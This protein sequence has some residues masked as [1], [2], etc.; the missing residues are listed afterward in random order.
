VRLYQRGGKG[1]YYAEFSIPGVGAPVRKSTHERDRRQA[2]AK[3]AAMLEAETRQWSRQ[4]LLFASR[5]NYRWERACADWHDARMREGWALATIE[6]DGQN[7]R[8]LAQATDGAGT[9]FFAGKL[10]R[11]IDGVTIGAYVTQALALGLTPETVAKR[12]HTLGQILTCARARNGTDGR[13]LLAEVPPFPALGR[14]R[15]PDGWGRALS[16][17]E[18]DALRLALP[19]T[20]ETAAATFTPGHRGGRAGKAVDQRGWAEICLWTAQ[21][22]DDVNHFVPELVNL[23]PVVGPAPRR[24]PPYSFV[25][26]NSKNRR[27]TA[28]KIREQVRRMTHPLRA[29]LER[30]QRVRGFADGVPIAGRWLRGNIWRDM[31]NAARRAGIA[32]VI[33]DRG[34][35]HLVSPNDLRRTAATWIAE[36]LAARGSG[37][38]KSAIEL[39][40]EFLGHRGIDVARAIYDRAAG[41]RLDQVTDVLDALAGPRVGPKSAPEL[42]ADIVPLRRQK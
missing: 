42:P 40:A 20:G 15:D 17:E 23:A 30:M 28:G 12:C 16:R 32:P 5:D 38:D 26:R 25:W 41:T 4:E 22:T 8:Y 13:P 11:D 21:H 35:P 27:R 34:K 10:L 31:S 2:W 6:I 36:E 19:T 1:V 9:P 18:W 24:L 14:S 39:I 29:A 7:L 37:P 3:A 33:D